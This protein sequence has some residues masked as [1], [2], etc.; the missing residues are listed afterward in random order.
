MTET[1]RTQLYLPI[2]QYQAIQR[3]ARVEKE[4]VASV[5]REAIKDYLAKRKK[6]LEKDWEKDPVNELI[7]IFEA[8]E[9]LSIDHDKYL[10][11]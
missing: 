11:G 4:S 6:I 9:D 2:T 3:V 10:Y 7:G 1:K 8:E 5:V